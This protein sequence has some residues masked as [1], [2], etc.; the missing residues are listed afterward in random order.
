MARGYYDRVPDVVMKWHGMDS[1][2]QSSTVH[3]Q[4]LLG[5]VQLVREA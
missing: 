3:D 5:P 4:G 1:R 2:M